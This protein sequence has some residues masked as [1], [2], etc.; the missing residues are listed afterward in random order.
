MVNPEGTYTIVRG[1]EFVDFYINLGVEK[2]TASKALGTHWAVKVWRDGNIWGAHFTCQELP[3]LNSLSA[4]AEGVEKCIDEPIAGGKAKVTFK[5]TG[6]AEFSTT[7]QSEKFGTIVVEEKYTDDGAHFKWSGKGKT[8]TEFWQRSIKIE[9]AYRFERGEN[10]EEFFKACGHPE[11]LNHSNDYKMYLCKKADSMNMIEC[12]G[13]LGKAHNTIRLDVE[14]PFRVPGDKEGSEGSYK[15]IMTKTGNGRSL[16]IVKTPE[17][18]IE[19]WKFTFSDCGLLLEALDKKSGATCKMYLKRFVETSGT[20][21]MVTQIGFEKFAHAMG[22]PCNQIQEMVGDCSARLTI[23]DK[24]NGFHHHKMTGKGNNVEVTFKIN[25]E[26]SFFHPILQEN[27]KAVATK[28]DNVL[29]STLHT[30]KGT[31][32]ASMTFNDTFTVM[33]VCHPGSGLGYKA[34]LERCCL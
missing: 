7:I 3:H 34:I 17:G 18:R 23:C 27:V 28:H 31:I 11:M 1:Q 9:G 16:M 29:C 8:I 6:E 22:V 14:A 10:I 12:F 24:G 33:A 19:E 32:K 13:D 25:E 30:S 4:A 5:K 21:K 15:A 20:Y 26:F 2:D